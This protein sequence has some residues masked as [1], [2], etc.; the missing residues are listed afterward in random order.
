MGVQ[1]GSAIHLKAATPAW[2]H[3]AAATRWVDGCG[4]LAYLHQPSCLTTTPSEPDSSGD[5]DEEEDE[6]KEE[7]WGGGIT[8]SPHSLSPE[9][10]PSLGD[11][12]SQQ[13]GISV[14]VHRMKHPRTGIGA[15]SDLSPQSGLSLVHFDLLRMSVCTGGDENNS[16]ARGFVGPAALIGHRGCPHRAPGVQSP[17][18]RGSTLGISCWCPPSMCKVLVIGLRLFCFSYFCHEFKKWCRGDR[19]C[20]SSVPV[21]HQRLVVASA[22]EVPG[23]GGTPQGAT[24][25]EV[26]DA[27]PRLGDSA[28]SLL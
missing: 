21:T 3:P 4:P 10:F 5:G 17:H 18:P 24:G 27:D 22:A 15:S 9:D 13:A 14:G 23:A 26:A 6:D 19:S 25:V 16:L 8:P 12:F 11:L 1:C 2:C 20:A 28:G 7:G